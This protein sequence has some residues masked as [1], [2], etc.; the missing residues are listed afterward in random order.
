MCGHSGPFRSGIVASVRIFRMGMTL[1][2]AFDAVMKAQG[3]STDKLQTRRIKDYFPKGTITWKEAASSVM[4][5]VSFSRMISPSPTSKIAPYLARGTFGGHANGRVV[6]EVP[7]TSYQLHL[8]PTAAVVARPGQR[9]IGVIRG[10]A[11][12]VDIVQTGGRYVEPVAGRPRRV[13][14]A[15]VSADAASNTIVV[16]AGVPIVCKL[17]D[18][19]QKA[20]DFTAGQF[21]SFDLADGATFTPESPSA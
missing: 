16:N 19:R 14:G 4:M 5:R 21:V 17:T 12:R 15:V 7:N 11:R 20:S 6:L 1:Q 2:N 3:K 13:Q 18:A 10:E 8:V 9:L